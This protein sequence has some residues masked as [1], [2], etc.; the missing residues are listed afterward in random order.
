MYLQFVFMYLN[1]VIEIDQKPKSI[2]I[3]KAITYLH[4]YFLSTYIYFL[5]ERIFQTFLITSTSTRTT[6]TT[7]CFAQQSTKRRMS[8]SKEIPIWFPFISPSFFLVF[9]FRFWFCF[10]NICFYSQPT[11]NLSSI[12]INIIHVFRIY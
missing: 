8:L 6:T 2:S 3:Y 10:C 11:L 1:T 5:C 12:Y 9:V 4:P 7:N